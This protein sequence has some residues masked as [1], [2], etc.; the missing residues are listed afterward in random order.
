MLTNGTPEYPKG[1]TPEFAEFL[2][3]QASWTRLCR[4]RLGSA[5]ALLAEQWVELLPKYPVKSEGFSFHDFKKQ[6]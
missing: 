6:R 5:W 2:H 4:A 1:K 3:I